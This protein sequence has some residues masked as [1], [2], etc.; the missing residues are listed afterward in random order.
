MRPVGQLSNGLVSAVDGHRLSFTC[1]AYGAD[2]KV[3]PAV[4]CREGSGCGLNAGSLAEAA[5]GDLEEFVATNTR[6]AGD[7]FF[8]Y[9]RRLGGGEK[10]LRSGI[11]VAGASH[12]PNRVPR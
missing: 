6:G 7:R 3:P 4:S 12:G 5:K 9:L 2:R 11:E 1:K 10:P 8:N